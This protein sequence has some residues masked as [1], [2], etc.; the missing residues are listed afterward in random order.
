M[1]KLIDAEIK[2]A[3]FVRAKPEAVYDALTTAEGLDAWF[4]V[5]SE[6]DARPGGSITFRWKATW[7]TPVHFH[8]SQLRVRCHENIN[9]APINHV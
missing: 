9:N 6:V 7:K 8:A 5:G 4:T 1:T 3:T 2:Q